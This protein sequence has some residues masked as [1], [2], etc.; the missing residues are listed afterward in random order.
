MNLRDY[1]AGTYRQQRQYRSFLPDKINHT[2][3][4]DDPVI[5]VLLEEAT[6]RLG[7]LNAFSIIVPDI[8]LF[9]RMH[10]VKEANTSSRI[11][12]TKTGIDEALMEKEDIVPEKRDDWQEVQNY[13]SAMTYAIE[14]L[15][16]IPLSNRLLRETHRILL[17]SA[18]GE[19]R[20]P[21]EFRTSQNWIGGSS[22][23]DAAYIPPV[24]TEV[25]DLMSD[26]EQFLHNE[27]IHVPHLIKIAIAHCQFESI[28]PFLDGN[29]RI[30]R[31]LI[32]LYLVSAGLLINPSLYLS[33]FFERN[34]P[35]YYDGLSRVRESNDLA[36]WIRFFLN[37]VI[38]TAGKGVDTFRNILSL[39][40]E[41][42]GKIVTLKR[43]AEHGRQLMQL[44]YRQPVVN[45]VQ[46]AQ[47][48]QIA[49][50][51]AY[52]LIED[53]QRLGILTEQTGQRR[54]RIFAFTRYIELFG[55][56]K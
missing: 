35:S 34:R 20:Q 27:D 4:W 19:H 30:G 16:R 29:G 40:N 56:E 48:L 21:G 31:L 9:I 25:P 46:V 51:N 14:E 6:R 39:K 50:K 55:V 10:I 12:G 13:I 5:N 11:E 47:Y 41:V 45:G 49:L 38:S 28:H 44:L 7:E 18:R 32:A 1:K 37:A 54:N 42:D 43:K 8:D 53:F 26:L 23:S 36:H 15:K 33:D 24:H 22:L 17:E 2:Y 3:V 52:P